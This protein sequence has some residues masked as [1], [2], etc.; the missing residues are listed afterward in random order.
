MCDH[1]GLLGL[2]AFL[3]G[4]LGLFGAIVRTLSQHP[5]QR[6]TLQFSDPGQR[7]FRNTHANEAELE[8]Y[9]QKFERAERARVERS[10]AQGRAG[11]SSLPRGARRG[12][13]PE[14]PYWPLA[15]TATPLATLSDL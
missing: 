3:D 4:L 1:S 2:R 10:S 9:A 15:R 12:A 8:E 13:G 7:T 5:G 11:G 14:A 6:Y